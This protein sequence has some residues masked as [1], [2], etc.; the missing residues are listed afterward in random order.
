MRVDLKLNAWFSSRLHR[1]LSRLLLESKYTYSAPFQL[2]YYL[3]V[4]LS[5]WFHYKLNLKPG[6]DTMVKP[7]KMCLAI[8]W[9]KPLFLLGES[10]FHSFYINRKKIIE[11]KL[12]QWSICATAAK[13]SNEKNPLVFVGYNNN[14][15]ECF[16][17]WLKQLLKFIKSKCFQLDTD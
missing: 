17:L 2:N 10:T 11:Q 13:K 16:Q 15:T 12:I 4:L 7:L 1:N 3:I 5:N 9:Q 14:G 6:K 8:S